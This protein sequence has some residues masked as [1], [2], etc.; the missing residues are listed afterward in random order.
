MMVQ[1]RAPGREQFWLEK[2]FIAVRVAA[3]KSGFS[4]DTIY[5]AIN[6]GSLAFKLDGGTKFVSASDLTNWMKDGASVHDPHK[7][8]RPDAPKRIDLSKE[9]AQLAKRGRQLV[10]GLDRPTAADP[11]KWRSRGFVT[12]REAAEITG[13]NLSW[14]YKL[15]N[16]GVLETKPDAFTYISVKSLIKWLG[17]DTAREYGLLPKNE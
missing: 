6:S 13:R 10:T 14:I 16:R 9:M 4:V 15:R 5:R 12:V 17:E 11:D 1:S 3:E 8:N 7:A 2:G